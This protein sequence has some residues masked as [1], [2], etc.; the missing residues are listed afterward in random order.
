MAFIHPETILH[1]SKSGRHVKAT[2]STT[3]TFLPWAGDTLLLY[4]YTYTNMLTRFPILA[5]EFF[6]HQHF[7]NA[8]PR[9]HKVTLV[10]RL[11]EATLQNKS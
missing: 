9:T 8:L 4:V 3:P 7:A 5:S 10:L 2:F 11:S 1:Y 6:P